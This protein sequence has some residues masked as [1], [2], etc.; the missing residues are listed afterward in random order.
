VR[1]ASSYA[2]SMICS[3]SLPNTCVTSGETIP[4]L[5]QTP[6]N[7][8]PPLENDKIYIALA[9]S[10][11]DNQ[12]AWLNFF[13]SYFEHPRHGEFPVAFGMGPPIL[14]L[15]PMRA[16][17]YYEHAGPNTEFFAD[18]SGIGYIQPDV[19]AKNYQDPAAVFDGYLEWT[20]KYQ[21]KLDL[22]TLRTVSGED[23]FLTHYAEKVSG[24]HSIFADMGRYGSHDK[25]Q[26]LTYSLPDGMPVFRAATSWRYGKTGFIREVNEQVGSVRPAFVNGFVH[27]WTFNMDAIAAIYDHR[28][29]DMVFVTPAQLAALYKQAVA[30][31]VVH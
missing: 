14:D 3:D 12:N 10:D 31:G 5:Q 29:P 8:P 2:I 20:N 27:C 30:Q 28:D 16:E 1:L 22:K 13:R 26:N 19:Y 21:A 7:P 24:M 9:V 18:V 25:I 23:D 15:Q 11:G 17:W 6:Q 4:P